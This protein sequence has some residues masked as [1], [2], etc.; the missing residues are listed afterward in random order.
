[1]S[2]VLSTQAGAHDLQSGVDRLLR[3]GTKLIFPRVTYACMHASNLL[4]I[5]LFI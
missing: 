4:K 3:F 2:M 1:M 5:Q